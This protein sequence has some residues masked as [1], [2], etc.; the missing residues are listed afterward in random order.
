VFRLVVCV[1][2]LVLLVLSPPAP[3][4]DAAKPVIDKTDLFEAGKGGYALYR[5]PGLVV[6][7]K[8]TLLAYCEARK[9]AGGDWGDI[10]ILM[11]RGTEGGQT[12]DEPR[13]VVRLEGT[14]ERN[15]AAVAQKL[16]KEGE[17]TVNNP[18]AVAD[19]DGTVHFL[20]CV[21]Y[22]RCFY[23]RSDDDGKSFGKPVEITATFEEFRKDYDWKVF[24]TGPAHGIQLTS[25]RLLVPVWLSR[26]TGGHAH[27]PSVVS[28]IFSDD[29]GKTWKRGDIVANETDP[30]TNPNETV[31]VQLADGRVMLNIRSESEKHRRAVAFSKD[32]ATGWT[33]PA[34]H[35]DLPEPICMASVVR[36]SLASTSDRNRLLFA[37]PNNLERGG[38]EAKP[39]QGRDRKKLSVRLSYDEGETWKVLKE[40]EPSWSGYSDL[41]VGP[42]GT[43]YCFYERGSGDDKS[44]VRTRFLTVAR[45]NLEY[46][47]DG[48]DSLPPGRPPK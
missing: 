21:E 44:S 20:Y 39:G 2:F 18:V 10:D 41:A 38:G 22:G 11:R 12:W 31:A 5:I 28:T 16:G 9:N 34:F 14:F 15:P 23:Q 43:V 45:F 6:T 3:G 7:A 30:L 24:A 8:G 13:K 19:R 33:K 35:E 40:L 29:G 27:R 36:L 17:I 32:G 25:G 42:D 26:G 37:N 48:K 47:T 1:G 46:L 4:A